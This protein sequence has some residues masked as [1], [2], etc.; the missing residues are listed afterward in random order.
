MFAV[1]VRTVSPLNDRRADFSTTNIVAHSQ[2]AGPNG[3]SDASSA[4]ARI[5]GTRVCALKKSVLV[6]CHRVETVSKI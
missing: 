2:V 1:F 3:S 5:V 4:S 6:L